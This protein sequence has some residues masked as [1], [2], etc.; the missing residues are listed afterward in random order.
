MKDA[1]EFFFDKGFIAFPLHLDIINIDGKPTKKPKFP[2]KWQSEKITKEKALM[3]A[4]AN[5][6]IKTFNFYNATAIKTGP[7]SNLFVLD[8]D[9]KSD[10]SDGHNFLNKNNIVI[11][12]DTPCVR[13]QS[14]GKHYYFRFPEKLKGISTSA[15]TKNNI[16]IRGEGGLVFAPPAYFKDGLKYKW[17]VKI[18]GENF[19]VPPQALIQ[20]IKSKKKPQSDSTHTLTPISSQKTLHEL[21]QKQKEVLSGLLHESATRERGTR[22]EADFKLIAWAIKIGLDK[23]EICGQVR[24]VGKFAE[25]GKQKQF[26]QYFDV[27]YSHALD[28]VQKDPEWKPPQTF[29]PK[30]NKINRNA[31]IDDELQRRVKG[32]I[33][34][35]FPLSEV[36]NAR[37][38]VHYFGD[39]IRFNFT[40]KKWHV[41]N[42]KVWEKDDRGM[43]YE[44]AK[45]LPLYIGMES[46]SLNLEPDKPGSKISDHQKWAVSSDTRYRVEGTVRL[47]STDPKITI[48]Q[49]DL[50]A[51]NYLLNINN[52]IYDLKNLKFIKHDPLL[53]QSKIAPVDYI[54][55]AEC[56]KWMEFLERIFNNNKVMIDFL[57]RIIGYSLTGNTGERC[58]FV[59]WGAGANGKSTFVNTIIALMGP[60]A[61]TSQYSKLGIKQDSQVS[62][63]LAR[64]HSARFVSVSEIPRSR[65]MDEGLIKQLTGNDRISARYLFKEDFEFYPQFKIFF[66]TN[67]RPP[68]EE[69]TEAIWDRIK[70]IPFN[71]R[72]PEDERVPNLHEVF[73]QEEL[74]GILNWALK[75]LE[76]YYERG[77]GVPP[78]V[79]AA[80]MEYRKEEDIIGQFIEECC[81]Q[82]EDSSYKAKDLY[83]AH[84]EWC[85]NSGIESMSN[86]MFGSTLKEKGFT[87][88]RSGKC[89]VWL[90][91]ELI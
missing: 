21:S 77:L 9:R 13:T 23:N 40:N 57:S 54:K 10:G 73:I 15:D 56:P 39:R 7:E 28:A 34:Q 3:L 16:D 89:N 90:G 66:N 18:N 74:P 46:G 48:S 44:Y 61:M 17:E 20:W 52:G 53:L 11:P 76:D 32:A 86:K 41:W 47:A 63:G 12:K 75:G 85:K 81:A 8:V 64:L 88:K 30:E 55:E 78:E 72:I 51:D 31:V 19:R 38:L 35:E 49:N 4:K 91:I 80:T 5:S 25:K 26:D 50:D 59:F 36:G 6:Y 1:I 29:K 37:R 60:Y 24:N 87:K 45:K 67:H 83:D 62:N 42:G 43:I 84:V 79:I 82:S 22:S 14:G 65:K 70:L 2:F 27:T 68:I 33:K 69:Q 71:V 58:F